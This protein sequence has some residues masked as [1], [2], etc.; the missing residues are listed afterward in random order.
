MRNLYEAQLRGMALRKLEGRTYV[1]PMVFVL[2]NIKLS[3]PDGAFKWI[4]QALLEESPWLFY[5]KVDPAF[6]PIR[7]DSRFDDAVRQLKFLSA[8]Q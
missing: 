2:L 1:S 4:N 5:M 8:D 6:K 3:D 7:N